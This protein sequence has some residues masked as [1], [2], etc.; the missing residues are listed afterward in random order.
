MQIDKTGRDVETV[1]LDLFSAL[2]VHHPNFAD[3]ITVDRDIRLV[4]HLTGP[5]NHVPASNHHV[6]CHESRLCMKL[7]Y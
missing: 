5:V 4:R 3:A 2:F 6:V 7:K 1:R